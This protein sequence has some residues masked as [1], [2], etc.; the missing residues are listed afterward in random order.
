MPRLVIVFHDGELLY[1]ETEELH[2]DL[3][4]IEADIT[5]VDS[6]GERAILP[7]AGIRQMIVDDVLPA[8]P[9]SELERWDRAAFHFLDGQ[10]FRAWV[11][12]D[13]LLGAHGGIWPT[14]E[15][16]SDELRRLAIPYSSL[17]GVFRLRQWDGRSPGER[18]SRGQGED[19]HLDQMVRVLAEREVRS[20]GGVSGR[21]GTGLLGR[22]RADART[23][24]TPAGDAPTEDADGP[25]H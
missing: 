1:A 15:P 9:E 12:P 7:L 2:F 3:P 21:G 8:P 24:D 13:V 14:V 10:V 22:M 16:G 6:N 25:T 19:H 5:N 4:V 17:K 20:R 11:A 23:A 18:T